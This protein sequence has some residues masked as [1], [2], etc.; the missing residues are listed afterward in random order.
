MSGNNNS[1]DWRSGIL[2]SL[3]SR[4]A[5][6][7]EPFK[8]LLLL[9]SRVQEQAITLQLENTR[10]LQMAGARTSANAGAEEPASAGDPNAGSADQQQKLEELK[11]KLYSLQEELTELHRRKG[12]N[13][14]Q[15]IDLSAQ[16]KTNEKD[17]NDQAKRLLQH[18]DTIEGLKAEVER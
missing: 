17:L 16:A 2:S 11:A 9:H 14:Q 1:C 13:A 4:N 6:E 5:R 15:V 8:E 18:E 3:R 10:L 7:S 12:E